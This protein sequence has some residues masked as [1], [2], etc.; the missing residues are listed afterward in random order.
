MDIPGEEE[1]QSVVI[2]VKGRNLNKTWEA[3]DC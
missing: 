3:L 2:K 1:R